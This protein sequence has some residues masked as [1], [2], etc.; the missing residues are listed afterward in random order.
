MA[1]PSTAANYVEVGQQVTD[2]LAPARLQPLRTNVDL[3]AHYLDRNGLNGLSVDDW[4]TTIWT[5]HKEGKLLWAVE[6]VIVVETKAQRDAKAAAKAFKDALKNK[7]NRRDVVETA[8]NNATDAQDAKAL[9][10]AKELKDV[11]S[12]IYS[13]IENYFKSHHSSGGRDYSG[14]ESGQAKLRVTLASVVG[15]Q[16]SDGTDKLLARV[17]MVQLGKA[18][19]TAVE[20]AFYRLS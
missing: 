13:R 6:P 1:T 18:A 12:K 3:I 19:L 9:A 16:A 15:G 14:T 2:R 11:K 20:S 10:E 5:L 7:P 17:T 4:M 8:K